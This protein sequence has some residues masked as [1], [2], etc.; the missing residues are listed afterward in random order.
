MKTAFNI[1]Q[2]AKGMTLKD[3]ARILIADVEE[4]CRTDGKS[5][6]TATEKDAI[7]ED[8]GKHYELREINRIYNLYQ[9]V[10][11]I[12]LDVYSRLQTLVIQIDA[13]E[14]II[15]AG[16]LAGNAMETIDRILHDV[17][18]DE[19]KEKMYKKYDFDIKLV[20]KHNLLADGKLQPQLVESFMSVVALVKVLRGY[21]Y[22]MEYVQS[23]SDVQVIMEKEKDTL[24]DCN[25]L[26]ETVVELSETFRVMRVFRDYDVIE[27]VNDEV[28]KLIDTLQ[29]MKKA[30]ELAEEEKESRREKV[31]KYLER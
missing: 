28:Q 14:K 21:M 2:L 3:K 23:K 1:T 9:T 15:L 22:D 5:L 20:S 11:F 24:N 19:D 25:K 27:E 12:S 7:V 26:I 18:P 10:Y 31:D 6:L 4:K 29:D 13:V 30:T 17:V 8:A 16:Y